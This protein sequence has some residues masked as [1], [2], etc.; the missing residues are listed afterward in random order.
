MSMMQ[1]ALD[2]IEKGNIERKLADQDHQLQMQ[3]IQNRSAR[4]HLNARI[5]EAT[6]SA[7]NSDNQ[8]TALAVIGA[9]NTQV[10]DAQ[11]EALKSAMD[12]LAKVTGISV[13]MLAIKY[14]KVFVDKMRTHALNENPYIANNYRALGSRASLECMLD[15]A[16]NDSEPNGAHSKVIREITRYKT[17]A[18]VS[19]ETICQNV[20][21]L[22]PST[23]L[24]ELF[25]NA[26]DAVDKIIAEKEH[27]L[28]PQTPKPPIFSNSTLQGLTTSCKLAIS[29][30]SKC[31]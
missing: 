19:K 20:S 13:D 26:A 4:S 8:A 18:Y 27:W 9:Y 30:A 7:Q 22:W 21:W 28:K 31:E 14:Q 6:S 3:A 16:R 25:T 29:I 12:D 24:P 11:L 15:E 1:R 2:E 23:V 10:Q 17:H 5:N